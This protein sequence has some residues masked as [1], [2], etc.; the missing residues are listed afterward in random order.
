M[1][2]RCQEFIGVRCIEAAN[3]N[4]E[5]KHLYNMH[6]TDTEIIR[7][8]DCGR[9]SETLKFSDGEAGAGCEVV[10]F[11]N[12]HR[13]ETELEFFCAWAVRRDG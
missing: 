5:G 8:R 1:M 11:C 2:G 7:C 4:G 10:P 6:L 3:V 12:K 13:C 9:C